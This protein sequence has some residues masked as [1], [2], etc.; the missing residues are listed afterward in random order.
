MPVVICRESQFVFIRWDMKASNSV[1][2]A[3]T[4]TDSKSATQES[5]AGP[6]DGER[7]S[8]PLFMWYGR[9]RPESDFPP[10][11]PRN[12]TFDEQSDLSCDHPRA[13][14]ALD[15]APCL[16]VAERDQRESA[17]VASI[18]CRALHSEKSISTHASQ[19]CSSRVHHF[20]TQH[21]VR[22]DPDDGSAFPVHCIRIA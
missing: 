7:E 22:L 14:R 21:Y 6:R 12:D 4:A 1:S 15:V 19:P 11:I 20:D 17:D 9:H 3:A 5:P 10:E 13:H 18:Q 8:Q 16:E 2:Q